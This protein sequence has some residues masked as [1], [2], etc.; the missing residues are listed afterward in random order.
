MARLI[1]YSTLVFGLLHGC[2]SNLLTVHR[3]DIQQ[4]NAL[5]QERVDQLRRGMTPGQVRFLLGEPLLQDPFH[6][7]ER[8]DYVYYLKR[9]DGQTERR[10]VTVHFQDGRVE[11][12]RRREQG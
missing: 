3:L 7:G 9:G 1:L 10:R 4:G 11:A 5:E 6:G 8:W 12:I 2:G